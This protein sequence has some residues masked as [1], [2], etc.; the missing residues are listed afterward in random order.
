MQIVQRCVLI[1]WVMLIGL[2][3]TPPVRA[4]VPSGPLVVAA[5]FPAGVLMHY[6]VAQTDT[7]AF[8]VRR[9]G[10]YGQELWASDG[11]V[12][13]T[14]KL[15]AGLGNIFGI[16]VSGHYLFLNADDGVHGLEPWLSDGTVAGTRR[17]AELAPTAAGSI[18]FVIGSRGATTVLAAKDY[19]WISDGTAAGTYQILNTRASRAVFLK[20]DQ[21]VISAR[22]DQEVLQLWSYNTTTRT[23]QVLKQEFAPNGFLLLFEDAVINNGIVLQWIDNTSVPWLM[24]T[25]GTVANTRQIAPI[26]AQ[27]IVSIGERLVIAGTSFPDRSTRTWVSDGTSAGTMLIATPY[28]YMSPSFTLLAAIGNRAYYFVKDYSTRDALEL[29]Q[30]DGT[31]IGT[32]AITTISSDRNALL[33]NL[34]RYE[35]VLYFQLY[36]DAELSLWRSDGTR[37]GTNQVSI[38][39]GGSWNS[40]LLNPFEFTQPLFWLEQDSGTSGYYTGLIVSDGTPLGTRRIPGLENGA[41]LSMRR[42]GDSPVLVITS[43]EGDMVLLGGTIASAS[44]RLPDTLIGRVHGPATI[45]L[46]YATNGAAASGVQVS[47]TLPVGAQYR[48]NSAGVAPTIQGTTLIW[49]LPDL[50]AWETRRLDVAIELPDDPLGTVYS[51][52]AGMT[53]SSAG[54]LPA[55]ATAAADIVT[56]EQVLLPVVQN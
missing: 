1:M 52:E 38:V 8:F 55:Q 21:L 6:L 16:T 35:D 27:D 53:T 15:R 10:T 44:V 40:D 24:Y 9:V 56:N 41:R 13:G 2:G 33:R 46:Q 34:R 11:T 39:G 45:P 4:A 32:Y 22:T 3:S 17:F 51:I 42:A 49:S 28:P 23:A 47:L 5:T 50:A 12:A 14:Q 37:A 25:D 26:Q 48:G 19:T 29:W 30:T 20:A 18:A 54:A 31:A 43:S 7:H 36:R